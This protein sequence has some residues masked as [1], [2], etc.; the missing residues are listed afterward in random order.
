MSHPSSN[1]PGAPPTAPPPAIMPATS[2]RPASPYDLPGATATKLP[3]YDAAAAADQME[4]DPTPA[5]LYSSANNIDT[6]MP[7][8]PA[9]E[10]RPGAPLHPAIG[11]SPAPS[12]I[13]GGSTIMGVAGGAKSSQYLA[14]LKQERSTHAHATGTDGNNARWS[15]Y[16]G[17]GGAGAGAGGSG[18]SAH[19]SALSRSTSINGALGPSRARQFDSEIGLPISSDP[20]KAKLERAAV[21]NTLKPLPRLRSEQSAL[22]NGGHRFFALQAAA[23]RSREE[24]KGKPD[25]IKWVG[26]S[27]S[28]DYELSERLGQ[29]TF[30]VVQRGRDKRNDRD[31]ALKKVVV[32]EEKDGIPITTIREIKLLK[33]LRHSAV[34]P[35][36]DIVYEPP[37]LLHNE[38]R[39]LIERGIDPATYLRDKEA[40]SS[41]A[42]SGTGYSGG[43]ARGTIYMVEPYM[44]HDLNGLLENQQISKLP[45][46]QIKLYMKQL[47]E[48]TLYLHKNRIL[49]RDMKAA[50]LL[51]NNEGSLQIADFGLA[52]PF[53]DSN[54]YSENFNSRSKT[55]DDLNAASSSRYGG[56]NNKAIDDVDNDQRP[57][58]KGKGKAHGSSRTD[59]TGMVVTRW[60]RPPELLAGMKNYGPAVDMWGLGCILG[61][62]YL[63]RPMFKGSSEINQMQLIVNA[64]GPPTRTNYP[65]WWNLTG[66]RDA[67]PSGRPDFG[68][69]TVGQKEFA[70]EANSTLQHF[71]W[72][73]GLDCDH[74]MLHLLQQMLQLDPKKRISAREALAHPWFWTRPYPADPKKLPKYEPSKEMDRAKREAKQLALMEQQQKALGGPQGMMGM[75]YNNH[76]HPHG[77]HPHAHQQQHGGGMHHGRPHMPHQHS[78][79]HLHGHGHGMGVGVGG[80]NRAN[81][82]GPR[83]TL[84]ARPT[85][86]LPP[87][88]GPGAAP[89]YGAPS[90]R[91]TLPMGGGGGAGPVGPGVGQG[92]QGPSGV[93]MGPVGVVG[94]SG[95]VGAG[96]PMINAYGPPRRSNVPG[97]GP[98][99]LPPGLGAGG[100]RP[101]PPG[102]PPP[103]PPPPPTFSDP[104]NPSASSSLPYSNW[105]SQ[106]GGGGVGPGGGGGG[107]G[108]ADLH[109]GH[110]HGYHGQGQGHGQGHGQTHSSSDAPPASNWAFNPAEATGFQ[111]RPF[112]DRMGGPGGPPGG[113]GGGGPGGFGRRGGF[114]PGG[115][116]GGRPRFSG[117]GGPPGGG[118][119]GGVGRF[120]F[121]N[122][123]SNRGGPPMGMD[124]NSTSLGGGSMGQAPVS[125]Q[126]QQQGPRGPAESRWGPA[127]GGGRAPQPYEDM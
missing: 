20:A 2:K 113:G 96:G 23:K 8:A 118:G 69:K 21:F 65:D 38:I 110:G 45:P 6:V 70:S 76:G 127:R 42:P 75:G 86:G 52:R 9:F 3:R 114:Q 94:P 97:V 36:I 92:S 103:L 74:Q 46:S 87:G 13:K 11:Q 90:A 47:L 100:V 53:T 57:A 29:G 64:V 125:P 22:Y 126:Q 33:I 28:S 34:I 107:G 111:R 67:D 7:D 18:G 14:A 85:M 73:H 105:V 26:C 82:G 88:Y 27:A 99:G 77:A 63:K 122:N 59:Y 68:G 40:G 54:L 124:S 101:P 80:M 12:S 104:N 91:M 41:S 24:R 39:S 93:G 30:G 5:D 35:V 37:A 89:V 16:G 58:W 109:S 19:Q 121:N 106:S 72:G 95:A 123:N 83:G 108:G 10:T 15:A 102:A 116:P 31:V 120:G 78:H 32:H 61:E 50:N 4:M 1:T 79:G 66:V 62:M 44:D 112:R 84:P 48:G 60:Y 71:F 81:G 98:P 49:H 119:G 25:Q 55:E 115:P 117:G 56:P 17:G 43:A 51:I